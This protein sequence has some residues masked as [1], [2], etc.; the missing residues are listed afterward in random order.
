VK[1]EIADYTYTDVTCWSA[2]LWP[3]VRSIIEKTPL[4][5]PRKAFDLG[6][7]NGSIANLLHGL[8]FEVIGVDYSESGISLA[9][10]SFPQVAFYRDSVYDDLAACYGQFSLVVSLEVVEHCYEPRRFARAL[11][12]L[13]ADG[14][15][16]I[17]STPYH[18][19]MKNLALAVAGKWDRHLSPLWDGGHIKFFSKLTLRALLIEAGFGNV[20]II[21]AGRIPPLAKSMIAIASK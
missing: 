8:G 4:N 17:I 13:V 11:C 2:D 19:Y 9:R 15:I 10:R 6:C 18:G 5:G 21:R 12:D 14:G 3:T 7:G 20:H 1:N 16:A